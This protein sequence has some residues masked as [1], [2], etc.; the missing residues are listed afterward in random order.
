MIDDDLG[1]LGDRED[2]HQVEKELEGRD[3]RRSSPDG[4]VGGHLPMVEWNRRGVV[5]IS[6]PAERL[7]AARPTWDDGSGPLFTD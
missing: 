3:P 1:H 7:S 6:R 2:E 4:Q 5:S